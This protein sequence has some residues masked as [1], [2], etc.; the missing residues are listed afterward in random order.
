MV[1]LAGFVLALFAPLLSLVFYI[2]VAL[3]FAGIRQGT[4]T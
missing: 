1:Y 4:R 2:A 3:F